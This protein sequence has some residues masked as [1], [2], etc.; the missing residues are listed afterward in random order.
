MT[1]I[2]A[3]TGIKQYLTYVHYFV[4][5]SASLFTRDRRHPLQA[6]LKDS[7]IFLVDHIRTIRAEVS[8]QPDLLD[9]RF[10]LSDRGQKNFVLLRGLLEFS[11]PKGI[12]ISSD[13]HDR[14][15]KLL[16]TEDQAP[17]V[18]SYLQAISERFH[19]EIEFKA[20][21]K[22]ILHFENAMK[23]EQAKLYQ[24]LQACA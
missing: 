2:A 7:P 10:R 19:K 11:R 1:S 14:S 4:N 8:D 15:F 12:N 22:K 20:S 17:A 23:I 6:Y 3:F 16:L 13:I 9:I 24:S 21:L 18:T 5:S